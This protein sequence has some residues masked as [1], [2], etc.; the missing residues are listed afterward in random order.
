MFIEPVVQPDCQTV[1]GV[2]PEARRPTILIVE[3]RP[4]LSPAFDAMCSY[5]GIQV[6]TTSAEQNL[7]EALLVHRP[8]AVIAEFDGEQQDGGHV[9]KLVAD[10]D[11][12]L[13]C[14]LLTG[15]D[16]RLTGAADAI[17][18][19]WG[20]SQIHKLPDLSN[21]TGIVEFLFHAGRKGDCM[22]LLPC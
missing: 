17:E 1:P 11:P 13:P 2:S 5:L 9:L 3:D 18:E 6:E 14:L 15:G 7:I 21:L 10:Y 16:P 8:M 19:L 12:S 20:L 22:R 4:D